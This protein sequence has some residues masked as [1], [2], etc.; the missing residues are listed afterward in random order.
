MAKIEIIIETEECQA[1]TKGA[2]EYR[3]TLLI[4]NPDARPP[5]VPRAF[6]NGMP[7]T[8]P[9]V[10]EDYAVRQLGRALGRLIEMVSEG[11]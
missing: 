7:F 4:A 11:E 8:H 6:Y 9:H 3:T 10:S 5:F 2:V 1:T